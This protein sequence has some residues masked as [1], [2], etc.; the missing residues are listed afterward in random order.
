LSFRLEGNPQAQ[1][2]GAAVVDSVVL[3]SRMLL[4]SASTTDT[5]A[6]GM[7]A[8]VVSVT[9]P[10]MVPR[11]VPWPNTTPATKAKHNREKKQAN[12]ALEFKDASPKRVR[13]EDVP[14]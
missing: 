6:P 9:I 3:V 12:A 4:V 14:Q 2:H 1:A 7:I 10:R 8:P 11:S 5:A 13:T